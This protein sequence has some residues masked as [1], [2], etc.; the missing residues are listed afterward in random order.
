[1]GGTRAVHLSHR[2][3]YLQQGG[4]RSQW[5]QSGTHTR[6][7]GGT[8]IPTELQFPRACV[9]AAHQSRRQ[10]CA[11]STVRHSPSQDTLL[12]RCYSQ[13]PASE[14][15]PCTCSHG[16]TLGVGTDCRRLSNGRSDSPQATRRCSQRLSMEARES[17]SCFRLRGSAGFTAEGSRMTVTCRPLHA[18]SQKMRRNRRSCTG[19]SVDARRGADWIRT[20]SLSIPTA[21]ERCR[22]PLQ[23]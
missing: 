12:L 23:P 1:M 22:R 18:R 13:R 5:S 11:P 19:Q 20:A 21:T 3:T 10:A 8:S 9:C 2:K 15:E 7:P 4:R 6:T 16:A 14:C 17:I